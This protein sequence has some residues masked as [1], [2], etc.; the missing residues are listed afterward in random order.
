[1]KSLSYRQMDREIERERKEG[2]RKGREKRERR[3]KQDIR[4]SMTT[5]TYKE[6][7]SDLSKKIK[8]KTW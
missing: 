2:E 8:L 4:N 3:E 1:M 6:S 5:H 7:A